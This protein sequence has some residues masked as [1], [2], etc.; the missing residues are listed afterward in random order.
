LK[1]HLPSKGVFSISCAF[2]K[3]V[4]QASK[5]AA[6]RRVSGCDKPEVY[7]QNA[8]TQPWWSVLALAALRVHSGS[9]PL[10][11]LSLLNGL[12][13]RGHLNRYGFKVIVGPHPSCGVKW[14][15]VLPSGVAQG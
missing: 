15:N 12:D 6:N 13:R 10:R 4:M 9:W 7:C 8:Q 1:Y 3:V 5:A 14:S 11:H 2:V